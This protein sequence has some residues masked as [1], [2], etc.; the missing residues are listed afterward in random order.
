MELTVS[1]GTT[2]FRRLGQEYL[3]QDCTPQQSVPNTQDTQD[4][5]PRLT[6]VEWQQ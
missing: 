4:R 5:Q 3:C 2:Q 1:I 6:Q